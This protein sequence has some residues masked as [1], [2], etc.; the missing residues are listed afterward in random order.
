MF[1]GLLKGESPVRSG[2][3]AWAAGKTIDSIP[4][5]PSDVFS[6]EIK[7]EHMLMQPSDRPNRT[8]IDQTTQAD[9][10]SCCSDK[11]R[12][13]ATSTTRNGGRVVH[14]CGWLLAWIM[15]TITGSICMAGSFEDSF[16]G[17]TL[18]IDYNHM[19]S[20][21]AEHIGIA[22][23]LVEGIW[24]GNRKHLI[25]S[26]GLGPY[27]VEVF[28]KTSGQMI[29]TRGFACIFAEWQSTDEAR[30]GAWRSFEE[31]I[32]IPEPRETV[33]VRISRRHG[34]KPY[35]RVWETE[36]DPASRF[37]DR[38]PVQTQKVWTLF[39][40]G[41]PSEKVDL[42]LIGDGYTESQRDT[43]HQDVERLMKAFFSV[44]P[45]ASNRER[46]NVRAIDVASPATGITRPRG[47]VFRESP[48][49]LR[50]NSLDSERYVLTMEDRKWRNIA[51]AAPYDA[52][53]LLANDRKYG[54]GGIYNLYATAS[55][56]S[57]F[58]PYL[59]VH[60]FGHHFAGLAD[61]YFTSSVAYN[62]DDGPPAEPWEPNATA[63]TERDKIKWKDLIAADTPLPTPWDKPR[64]EETSRGFQKKRAE[65]RGALA[66]ESGLEA[67]FREEK[68]LFTGMLGS[69]PFA[70]KVGA[71][72]GSM[73]LSS[74]M[75]RPSVDCLMFTRDDVGFCP[76]CLR[77]IRK[78]I[79]FHAPA[80]GH[81]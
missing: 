9:A 51:A 37:V 26:T 3:A 50:Y 47:A 56:R 10:K 58:A 46:F 44:E 77:A 15:A 55:A 79:D 16:T 60:E 69:E 64:Y 41:H 57:E 52:V 59:V 30:Y 17:G 49:G 31:A 80:E 28:D 12:N 13:K 21:N 27:R 38:P 5:T 34:M 20:G 25:D 68:E 23:M 66:P 36:V 29:Y 67:L 54:G 6:T 72:E 33:L 62:K 53:I 4:Q 74:G 48:L 19:G 32:R 43:F 70:T 24:P 8:R 63:Q 76:V 2:N 22:R 42:L 1:N 39:R 73:Y 81:R 75:Y 7:K 40:H 65:L 78:M 18:R 14:F 11:L 61:E 35:V 71:F 45:F